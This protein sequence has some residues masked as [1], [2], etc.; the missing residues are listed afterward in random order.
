MNGPLETAMMKIK[1]LNVNVT[2]TVI[3][4]R[5]SFINML[6]DQVRNR[7]ITMI[8]TVRNRG[9]IGPVGIK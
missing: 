2:I 8:V 3:T 6:S 5:F 7:G 9:P 1:R 4:R